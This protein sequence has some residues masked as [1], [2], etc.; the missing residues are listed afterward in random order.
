M[1]GSL[2]PFCLRQQQSTAA[3]PAQNP[4]ANSHP[5]T[6]PIP[7]KFVNLQVLPKDI[8]KPKLVNMMKQFS[9][10]F[11]VRCSY[12]HTVSDDLT[13]GSFDSDEKPTKLKARE[14][15]RAILELNNSSPSRSR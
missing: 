8:T 9:I 13:E 6:N 7:D 4:P 14:M 3:P 2:I 10:T 15:I 11:A 12:C 5:Q 1:I